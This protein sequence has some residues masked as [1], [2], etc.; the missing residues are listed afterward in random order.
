MT[1]DLIR[2]VICEY[3]YV[4]V[5]DCVIGTSIISILLLYQ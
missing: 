3:F 2:E 4:Y 5:Y 1:S